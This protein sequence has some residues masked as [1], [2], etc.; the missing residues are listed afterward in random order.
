MCRPWLASVTVGVDLLVNWEILK[1]PFFKGF[2][3]PLL[4]NQ[5]VRDVRG[6]CEPWDVKTKCGGPCAKRGIRAWS[7]GISIVNRIV[8]GLLIEVCGVSVIATLS[9]KGHPVILCLSWAQ[10]L[11]SSYLYYFA[12]DLHSKWFEPSQEGHAGW[13]SADFFIVAI[14][15]FKMPVGC[16]FQETPLCGTLPISLRPRSHQLRGGAN[17]SGY[18]LTVDGLQVFQYSLFPAWVTSHTF[19][20]QT[21]ASCPSCLLRS[22]THS[23]PNHRYTTVPYCSA[24]YLTLVQKLCHEPEY[25]SNPV[26]IN[27]LATGTFAA[28]NFYSALPTPVRLLKY[29]SCLSW[30]R[31]C[32]CFIIMLIC[33]ICCIIAYTS[34]LSF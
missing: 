7:I 32:M 25:L 34:L 24:D 33:Y 6:S 11:P 17:P 15:C 29:S 23:R 30:P 21:Q 31:W 18:T 2:P 19:F 14:K 1:D 12:L 10:Q 4:E 13:R 9:F 5:H 27:F 20:G 22:E 8:F 16:S 26:Q 3:L 28:H